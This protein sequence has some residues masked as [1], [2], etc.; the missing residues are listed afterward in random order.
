M[1]I[2]QERHQWRT[3]NVMRQS[4]TNGMKLLQWSST[5]VLL[6][7]AL[8]VVLAMLKTTPITSF[9]RVITKWEKNLPNDFCWI[10]GKLYFYSS[11]SYMLVQSHCWKLILTYRRILQNLSRH[12][13]IRIFFVAKNIYFA[14]FSVFL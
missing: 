14:L 13:K 11:F 10:R 1:V 12:E 9:T 5:E 3:S 6:V 2:F 4:A 7:L 8:S